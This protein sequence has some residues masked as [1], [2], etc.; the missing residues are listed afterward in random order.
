MGVKC[1]SVS[2]LDVL[3]GDIP[4]EETIYRSEQGAILPA[5]SELAAAEKVL[6]DTGREF[7]LKETL[8]PIEAWYDYIVIDT[9][10]SLGIL[11]VNALTA[12]DRVIIPS[13][14]F[15][16]ARDNRII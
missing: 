3:T 12:A 11:T 4:V 13:G 2:V 5:L 16:S 10:P 15:L 7:R 8:E 6:K 9:P 1:P 14:R